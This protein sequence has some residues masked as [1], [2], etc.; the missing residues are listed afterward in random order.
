MSLE[1][2]APLRRT[3]PPKRRTPL[4]AGKGLARGTSQ[5]KRTGRLKPMS[6]KRRAEH[7]ASRPVVAAVLAR[8][9]RCLLAGHSEAGRCFGHLTPH[10][11]RK[12]GQGGAWTLDNLVTLCSSHNDTWVE[13]NRPAAH[14]LGLVLDR[15]E[16][17][18]DAWARMRAAGLVPDLGAA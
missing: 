17:T 2:R 14:R 1:R 5:L 18:D 9:G 16:A 4:K 6:D 8:D 7:D 10:H 13:Q 12:D 3:G 15:G 11:L